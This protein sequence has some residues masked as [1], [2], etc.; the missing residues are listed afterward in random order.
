MAL[1][2]LSSSSSRCRLSRAL[3]CPSLVTSM[4]IRNESRL[5]INIYFTETAVRCSLVLTFNTPHENKTT[6]FISRD[7]DLYY[8]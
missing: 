5:E 7:S 2:L 4:S 6:T 1:I 3:L 8:S